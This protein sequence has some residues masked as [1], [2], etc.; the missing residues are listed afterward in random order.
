MWWIQRFGLHDSWNF[1]F[2]ALMDQQRANALCP[3]ADGSRVAEIAATQSQA[4]IGDKETH[5]QP[6]QSRIVLGEHCSYE[7]PFSYRLHQCPFRSE[8]L[9]NQ[10]PVSFAFLID[11]QTD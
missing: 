9:A 1:F 10:L 11:H 2:H 4:T 6:L 3:G 8:E 7:P 5:A